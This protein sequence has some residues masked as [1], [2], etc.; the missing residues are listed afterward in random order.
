MKTQENNY[1][2]FG[3][4]D[5]DQVEYAEAMGKDPN[6]FKVEPRKQAK[7]ERYNICDR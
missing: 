4:K 5:E 6:I 2:H 1:S 7:L 3:I